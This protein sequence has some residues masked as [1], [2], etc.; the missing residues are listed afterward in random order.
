MHNS[1]FSQHTDAPSG[2]VIYT[3]G[4][5]LPVVIRTLATTVVE[6]KTAS[7]TSDVGRLYALISLVTGIGNL[8][9]GPSLAWAFGVG[10]RL[11]QAWVGLPFAIATVLFLVMA[12]VMFIIRI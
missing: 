4:S 3:L 9:A 10:M 8:I 11:G 6:A 12:P 2:I 7:K 1:A 5:G